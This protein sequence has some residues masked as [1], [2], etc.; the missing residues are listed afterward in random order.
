MTG[1]LEEGELGKEITGFS[2]LIQRLCIHCKAVVL[3][4]QVYEFCVGTSIKTMKKV[5]SFS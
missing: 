3:Q 5:V 4:I 2:L 1:S